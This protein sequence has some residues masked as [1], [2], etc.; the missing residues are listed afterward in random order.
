M[1]NSTRHSIVKA[2]TAHSEVLPTPFL[3]PA[4][5][6]AVAFCRRNYDRVCEVASYVMNKS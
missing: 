6:V 1:R 5:L 2:T 3:H 4:G